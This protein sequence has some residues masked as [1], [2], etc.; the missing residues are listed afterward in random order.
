M[1]SRR[2]RRA[3]RRED[4]DAMRVYLDGTRSAPEDPIG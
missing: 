4:V 1:T 3:S 2:G